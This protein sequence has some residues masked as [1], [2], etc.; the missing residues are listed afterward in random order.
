[1]PFYTSSSP[2]LPLLLVVTVAVVV[3]AAVVVTVIAVTVTVFSLCKEQSLLQISSK[4]KMS[5]D[6]VPADLFPIFQSM[7]F[8]P[9][10]TDVPTL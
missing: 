8:P 4:L 3:V 6:C 10:H 7:L 1:M 9:T 5:A 2:M